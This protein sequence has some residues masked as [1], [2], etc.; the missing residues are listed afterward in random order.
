MNLRGKN[1][2]VTGA[3]GFIGY[4][5]AERLLKEGEINI[6]GIDNLNS[7]Y[8]PAL[9]KRR[10]EILNQKDENRL[11]HF[12]KVDLKDK[13]KVNEIFEKYNPH[14]VVN[15]AAQAGVRYSLENPDT[16]LESNLLGFLNILEGCR[17]FNVEHLIY[18][19][20]SSVYGGNII[21]PYSEDHSVDHP[22]SLYAATKKSNEMLAHSYSHLFKI[23][24]TGLRFFTVYGPYGR[25]DMAPMIF[26]DSILNRKPINVF[27]NGD[28][29]RDF[30]FISD[31]VEAIYKCCL[32]KPISN[33]SFYDHRPEPSTSF[34]PH[35][36]FNVGSNNPINLMSFI[37]K[38]EDELGI[39]AIKKMRPMQPG[40]VKSTFADIT[41]LSEW[42]NYHPSTSF[43]KGIHLFAKWYKDYFKSDY[44]RKPS[45]N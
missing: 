15:L 13:N 40:D 42:I 31:I 25:P 34:A 33:K 7:Y 45:K 16:Y 21:M 38:L 41:K 23:P 18:A 44:Y 14:L 26:A 35:R 9:K 8:N 43:N 3:A 1:I 39:S 17:N 19:S 30:T 24:S 36:I 10:I 12:L 20:S 2:L 37:E 27:N 28:M 22:L 5:L 4:A 29:S 32:K 11:W 6:I